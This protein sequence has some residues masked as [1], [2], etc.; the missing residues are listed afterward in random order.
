MLSHPSSAFLI[1]SYFSIL[2]VARESD[3]VS[4]RQKADCQQRCIGI[5][6]IHD[7]LLIY[8]ACAHSALDCP[9]QSTVC[10]SILT[11]LSPSLSLSF[12]QGF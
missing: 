3:E 10:L 12:M 5:S 1:V 8:L 6:L 4:I 7:D 11:P 9:G 2:C